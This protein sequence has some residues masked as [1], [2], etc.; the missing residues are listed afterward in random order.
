MDDE[1]MQATAALLALLAAH[2]NVQC[3]PIIELLK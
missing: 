3:V 1:E 2:P